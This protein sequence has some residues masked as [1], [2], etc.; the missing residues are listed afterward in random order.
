MEGRGESALGKYRSVWA[1]HTLL[2]EGDEFFFSHPASLAVFEGELL[3]AEE[4]FGDE[5]DAAGGEGGGFLRGVGFRGNRAERASAPRDDGGGV[6]G[7]GVGL[8]ADDR[9][10]GEEERQGEYRERGDS[11][12]ARALAVGAREEAGEGERGEARGDEQEALPRGGGGELGERLLGGRAEEGSERGRGVAGFFGYVGEV[13]ANGGVGGILDES[14]GGVRGGF[15]EFVLLGKSQREVMVGRP[16]GRVFGEGFAPRFFG[17]GEF[18]G[19]VVGGRFP[20]GEGGRQEECEEE[21]RGEREEVAGEEEPERVEAGNAFRGE[22]GFSA[23]DPIGWERGGGAVEG[24]VAFEPEGGPGRS[25]GSGRGSRRGR[26][27]PS[28]EKGGGG[29]GGVG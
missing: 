16:V 13:P 25:V 2:P 4:G 29:R 22:G 15:A 23:G 7:R 21:E 8:P 24:A 5:G 12:G 1:G 10:D 27:V 18:S 28:G 20:G 19:S 9:G 17:G 3:P 26:R 11:D 14:G 6:G